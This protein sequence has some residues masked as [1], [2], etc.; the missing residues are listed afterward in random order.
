MD[1]QKTQLSEAF[2]ARMLALEQ[3]D[4]T[5]FIG[6]SRVFFQKGETEKGLQILRLMVEASDESRRETALVEIAS[7]ESVKSQIA[8]ITEIEE[9]INLN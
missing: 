6:L 4:A 1:S 3:F 8:K 5:N 9:N 7:L 2:F